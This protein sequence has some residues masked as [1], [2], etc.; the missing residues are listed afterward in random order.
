MALL[1][2]TPPCVLCCACQSPR[3]GAPSAGGPIVQAPCGADFARQTE[4]STAAPVAFHVAQSLGEQKPLTMP[5]SSGQASGAAAQGLSEAIA[6]PLATTPP[7]ETP[8]SRLLD[9]ALTRSPA[10]GEPRALPAKLIFDG[11]PAEE[12]DRPLSPTKVKPRPLALAL[13][14]FLS[15]RPDEAIRHLQSYAPRDQEIVMRLLPLLAAIDQHGVAT[16]QPQSEQIQQH[17][18]TLAEIETELRPLAPLLLE[19]LTFCHDIRGYGL[20]NQVKSNRFQPGE[21]CW[22]YAEMRNLV[23][24]RLPNGTYQVRLRG[25][26]ELFGADG[27]PIGRVD[28]MASESS[29]ASPRLDNFVRM[30]FRVPPQLAPGQYSVRVRIDDVHTG[31]AAEAL[32]PFQVVSQR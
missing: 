20:I 17:L 16:A 11:P 24:R 10:E 6:P 1:L 22:L 19:R 29:S 25:M 8:P 26:I 30:E 5:S 4:P 13:E 21:S 3:P 9:Q 28:R 18:R 14:A 15:N 32:L 7:L 2:L 27:K 31:R 12:L 23:D